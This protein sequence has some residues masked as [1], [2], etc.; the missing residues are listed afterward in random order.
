MF[1]EDASGWQTFKCGK[2]GELTENI[3]TFA[4]PFESQ[5]YTFRM[6]F[7][8]D[9]WNRIQQMTY[10]DGEVVSYG[11]N[12][13]GMLDSIGGQ[14]GSFS[15]PYIKHIAYNQYELKDS[16]LYGN[17]TLAT[18]GYDVLMRLQKLRS[19][20]GTGPAELMQDITYD[21][22]AASNITYINNQATML[23]CGLGGKY[24]SSYTYDNL[25]RLSSAGGN[26]D[27]GTMT[28]T[29][30]LSMGYHPNGRIA[31]KLL[32][33]DILDHLGNVTT[34]N[35]DNLYSYPIGKN[36]LEQTLDRNNLQIQ[37]F[38]W[39]QAGNMTK[40]RLQTEC[41]RWLCWDEENRLQGV[42]DCNY[43]SLYQ[44]DANGERTYKLTGQYR[45][46]NINGRYFPY[47]VLDNPTLYASPYVVCTPKGYTKHYYA[48]SERVASKIGNGCL[49]DLCKSINAY[50]D[51]NRKN[52][53]ANSYLL[54]CNSENDTLKKEVGTQLPLW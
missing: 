7:E 35:Y 32:Q 53:L 3:R 45:Y 40:H 14:K 2:L 23:S 33:A 5:P 18:Y 9:S 30:V 4:L 15:H 17:G 26:W 11:Y 50:A 13:G 37:T 44:Y 46:Q 41:T 34:K 19:Y 20:T 8:Y 10:P 29:Y 38:G 28:N 51:F 6:N 24:E 31:K 16:V 22:D 12:L 21:Y 25:Y 43:A 1:Y 42:A 52:L 27:N 49:Q 47:A 36:T 54:D 48:E 39:D